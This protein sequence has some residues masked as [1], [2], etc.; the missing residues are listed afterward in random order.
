LSGLRPETERLSKKSENLHLQETSLMSRSLTLKK[1]EVLKC[2]DVVSWKVSLEE[3]LVCDAS[4]ADGVPNAALT[5]DGP[6]AVLKCK[7]FKIV[8]SEGDAS[9]CEALN[10]YEG[11]LE[12]D[13]EKVEVIKGNDNDGCGLPFIYGVKLLNG[14]KAVGCD[15][16]N[17]LVGA[18]VGQGAKEL[19][20]VTVSNNRYGVVIETNTTVKIASM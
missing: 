15:I 4:D 20:D 8:Q 7:G 9:T 19:S 12:A 1:S 17:F 6:G 3:N 13:S 5:L 11:H 16:E 18:Y 10:E 2:G 14:A